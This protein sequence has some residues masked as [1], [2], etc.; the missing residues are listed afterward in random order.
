[1]RLT[2]DLPVRR[3]PW[4]IA[5]LSAFLPLAPALAADDFLPV[6]EA[7]KVS[8]A[9]DAGD[10]V[11]IL[12]AAPGY[13]LY[14]DRL[15]FESATP[16]VT[17]GEPSLP[18]GLDHEDEFFGKQVIYRDRVQ[19]GVPV[20]FAGAAQDFELK[21]KLQGCADAGL[22]YPPQ[23]WSVPVS[24][25]VDSA[26]AAPAANAA[27][28]PPDGGFNLRSLLGSGAKSDADF[29]TVDQA[30]SLSATSPARDRV[31]LHWVIADDYYLYRD[32]V[33]VKTTA[34]DVQLGKPSI[35]GGETRT[36]EYFGEQVV[37]LGE[38]VADVGVSAA[39]GVTEVPIEVSYQGCAEAGLCYPPTKKTFVVTLA[40]AGA[41]DAVASSGPGPMRSEQDLLAD[42]IRDGNLL[43]VLATFFGFGLLLA[44]TPCVLPM[45][46]IL[47]GIIVGAGQGRPVSRGR[48]FSLSLA[49]VLGMALTYTV[50]GAVFAAA[51][52]QAQAF[53]Q[54]PWMI[55]LFAALFVWLALG[56]FGL[57]NLQ[58][59]SW[60][61]DRLSR[62]S[63]QQRQGTLVGTAIMGALS[64]LIV[65]A[66]VAP[67]L[68]A[69]LAVI[70]Q[71]GDVFRGGAAL[72]ALSLGMGAPLLV[73]GA[74][75]GALLPRAGA[76]M[77]TVK[78]VFGVMLL[79]VAIWMLGRILPGPV[80]LG[81]WA[82]LAFVTGYWLLLPGGNRDQTSGAARGTSV[83][84]RGLGALAMVYGVLMLIGALS[85]RS[86]PLQP[87]AG[88]G[89]PAGSAAGGAAGG[90][91]HGIEFK[92][93][94]SSADL[95]RE[96]AAATAAGKTV[97][98][99]FYADWCVSCKEM[100]KYTFPHADVQ[101]ALQGTVKLQADVTANDEVDQALMQR[102]GI[103]GPPSILFFGRDG[104]EKPD[105]RVV[106]FKPA[107]E[108]APH[109]RQAFG[110]SVP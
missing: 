60:L 71:S 62:L 46:P 65:T 68:V 87:L 98:L 69:S 79:G 10:L 110:G 81:L 3:R 28:P 23:T 78:Q 53:F 61:Q 95:D 108:F 59:P 58:V 90:P 41:A 38:M 106:G 32:K 80:T 101:Q 48:A 4:L 47:S 2:P 14:R 6:R 8:T 30:F 40:A 31:R 109:I 5:L 39:A 27:A 37:F 18:A 93:I 104:V 35:P 76:W 100:E 51:G 103:L 13:Y 25:P 84:R 70:G 89:A 16:G 63:N 24:W 20:T 99:D 56:M 55:V 105:Y 43:A 107:E 82:V 91:A 36:D 42:K 97:L 11:V 1:M 88:V 102:F 29:L 85:G 21:L 72:F 64:S 9:A 54:K 83:V 19:V 74:S 96:I 86:D 92:R 26:D 17:L 77:D 57:F 45:V 34:A 22:C 12:T 50:A 67:P 66:C 94:K 44:F 49:Y 33:T 73:V 75:A 52:Q 15:A 7:Y